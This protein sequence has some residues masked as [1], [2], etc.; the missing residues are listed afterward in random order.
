MK[1]GAIVAGLDLGSTKTCAVIAE[2]FGDRKSAQARILGVGISS[3]SGVRRGVVRDIEETTN[4]IVKAMQDAELMAGVKIGSVFC[5]IAGDHVRATS[6][7]GVAAVRVAEITR[8]DVMRAH[9]PAL[10]ISQGNDREL[11]HHIPQEYKVDAQ[12]GINDPVGMTGL[13]LEVDMYLITVQSTAA[14]N[15][16]HAVERAG[17]RVGAL[18]L[19]SLASESATLTDEEKE[20]GCVLVEVGGGSTDIAV[21]KDGKVRHLSTVPY[22]GM[23][24]TSDIVQAFGVTQADAETL[25]KDWGLAYMPLVDSE[26]MI[27]LPGTSGQGA[28]EAKR[29]LLVHVIQARLD[30]IFHLVIQKMEQSEFSGRL[31][32]GVIL[33]G[34][35]AHTPGIIELAREVFAMPVRVGAPTQRISGLVGSVQAPQYAVPV[36]L[37]LH[38]AQKQ[39]GVLYGD[40]VI[41]RVLG[42]IK[43]WL[44]EIF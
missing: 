20:L 2:A 39:A 19:E 15:L 33:T 37:A 28:R 9:E 43:R 5:G 6:S 10:A 18:V 13:R 32:A 42:P 23:H 14:Q 16:R 11:L 41:G 24:V 21:F 7:E 27:S 26:Q 25:K 1:Q 12:D 31:P 40:G 36:G 38:A 3:S 44:Q 30:E 35:V 17:Y 29:E 22:A 4:S 34:G 8:A